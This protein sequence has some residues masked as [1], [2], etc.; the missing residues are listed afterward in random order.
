MQS[1]RFQVRYRPDEGAT[2]VSTGIGFAPTVYRAIG[3]DSKKDVIFLI[4][5]A[6]QPK[7]FPWAAGCFP[8]PESRIAK[9]F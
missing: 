7:N 1:R 3:N 6:I 9:S 4:V 8:A 5:G 2:Y